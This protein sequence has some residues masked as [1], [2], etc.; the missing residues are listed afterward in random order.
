[1]NAAAGVPVNSKNPNSMESFRYSAAPKA[2][3]PR[4]GKTAN[5]KRPRFPGRRRGR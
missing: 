3:G 1:M 2:I 4:F 5:P